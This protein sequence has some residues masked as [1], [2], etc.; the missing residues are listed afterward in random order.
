MADVPAH[1]WTL[2]SADGWG[3]LSARILRSITDGEDEY[4]VHEVAIQS[5]YWAREARGTPLDLTDDAHVQLFQMAFSR[6]GL[7]LFR[8]ALEEWIVTPREE[9][10]VIEG[11]ESRLALELARSAEHH[12]LERYIVQVELG[13]P[14]IAVGWRGPTDPTCIRELWESLRDALRHTKAGI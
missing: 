14:R 7:E 11:A 12:K 10:L 3:R 8:D 4:Y 5:R 2:P 13:G 1:T 9:T 6:R